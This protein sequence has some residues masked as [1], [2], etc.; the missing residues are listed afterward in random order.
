ME[1]L[2]QDVKYGLRTLAKSPG[3]TAVAVLSLAL[4]IGANTTIFTI[5]NAVFLNALPVQDAPSLYQIDT[6]DPKS[7]DLSANFSKIG[8]SYPNYQDVRD[9]NHVFSGVAAFTF[10]TLTWNN[11]GAFKQIPG[12]LVTANYFD[13]LGVK[14]LLGRTFFPDEDSKP[15]GNNVAV[16]SYSIWS[17]DLGGDRNVIGRQMIL[18]TQS[19]TIIGVAPRNFRG[20]FTLL[21]PDVI[22]IPTSMHDQVLAGH[23]AEFFLNR[24]A[25]LMNAFG[26]LKPGVAPAQAGA[27]LNTIGARLAKEFPIENNGRTFVI[28]PL[29]DAALGINQHSQFVLIGGVM[30]TVVGLVLLIACVNLANLLLARAAKRDKEMSIRAALGAGR[31]RL[32]RQMLTESVLLSLVGGAAGLLVAYWGRTALWSFRPPFLDA[33]TFNL[34]LD[35][36]VLGFTLVLSV[37]TGIVFG[38]LPAI[39]VSRPDLNAA[40]KVGGRG[41]TM[42]WGRNWFRG[43]L[44]VAEIAL[45]LVPLVGAGL[46]VR[47]MRNAQNLD[48]GFESRK[49]MVMNVDLG[50]AR[51]QPEK[52]QQFYRDS[53]ARAQ[54]VP[55]VEAAAISSAAPLGGGFGR[56][57]FLEGQEGAPGYHGTLT[58]V[59]QI[60]PD[61]FSTMRIPMISGRAFTEFDRQ[62]TTLVAIVNEATAKRSWP[63]QDPI[64]KRFHFFA[65]PYFR[66]VVGVVRN[67]VQ[68]QIGEDP[69]AVVYTPLQQDFSPFATILARTAGNPASLLGAVREQ[70]QSLDRNLPITGVSTITDIMGQGLWAA[71]MGAAL[72]GLFGLL[73]LVLASVGL[74]GVMAYSV[75]Q[76]TPEIGIRMAMGAQQGAILRMVMGQG[77]RLTLVG[78]AIGLGL[79][80][81][82]TRLLSD[83]LYGVSATDW[84]TFAGVPLVLAI[85]ALSACYIPAQ[86]AMRVDPLVALRY[87]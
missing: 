26:R 63:G 82:A 48:P 20:T 66:Q 80:Y 3:F 86:R 69:V 45:A 30:M 53:V 44:V 40:L 1:T 9:Q 28:S 76:R 72:L 2:W 42:G 78:I 50:A 54:A 7:S 47:S 79:S 36:R 10:P 35:G 23:F 8:I 81:F 27:E 68:N 83:L 70:I 62:N 19:Y 11:H 14:P 25:V 85:V 37:L 22:W 6:T 29:A 38:A 32:L 43:A 56:T 41:G 16:I 13:V 77:L 74:Y 64:G 18:N 15:G 75:A 17:R 57:V 4:G 71:R 67:S 58:T 39:R 87:E 84:I 52:V 65:D 51:Y 31:G 60:S 33:E 55:G 5:I 61:Y 12:L 46:F 59:D 24:R 34:A 73:A 21:G 49:L